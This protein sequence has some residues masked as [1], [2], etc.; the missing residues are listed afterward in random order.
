[1]DPNVPAVFPR[2]NAPAD[3]PNRNTA[4]RP[5]PQAGN[6]QPYPSELLRMDP[7]VPVIIPRNDRPATRP[8]RGNDG[9][10][11][12]GEAG[13]VAA[14][15]PA[16][17]PSEQVLTDALGMLSG[18]G[19]PDLS[20][21]TG[22]NTVAVV[23][24]VHNIGMLPTSQLH[25]SVLRAVR[26]AHDNPEQLVRNLL[27]LVTANPPVMPNRPGST[28]QP[29][30]RP[31]QAGATA[32]ARPRMPS[33]DTL[34]DA[35]GML[36][37]THDA[38]LTAVTGRNT[39]NVINH[40][41]D[42]ATRPTSELASSVRRAARSA[43]DNPQQLVH[44]LLA[45]ATANPPVLSSRPGS[46]V[47]TA[48]ADARRPMPSQETL[49]DAVGM[50]TGT[51]DADL[52]EVTGRNTLN[53]I[54][55]LH[56]IGTRSARSPL[57]PRVREAAQQAGNDPAQL[58][59]N[60]L[61]LATAN[62][63]VLSS[64]PGSSVQTAEADAS[65]RFP[66]LEMLEAL[67]DAVGMLTGT[68]DADLTEL[69]ALNTQNVIDHLQDIVAPTREYPLRPIVREAAQQAGNNPEQLVR[70]LL[71][72]VTADPPVRSNRPSSSLQPRLPS[73]EAL[74]DA[75]GMLTGARGADLTEVTGRNTLDVINHLHDI[76]ARS[77]TARL[78][79]IVR[80]AAQQADNNPEQLVRNLLA[81][82]TANPPVL[83]DRP[84]SSVQPANAPV[85]AVRPG[86]PVRADRPGP[87]VR[88]DRPNNAGAGAM[89][90]A[91]SRIP[92]GSVLTEAAQIV[93][94]MHGQLANTPG[95]TDRHLSDAAALMRDIMSL[96]PSA[97]PPDVRRAAQRGHNDPAGL[98]QNLLGLVTTNRPG[99]APQQSDRPHETGMTRHPSRMPSTAV[100]TT[101]V[102]MLNTMQRAGISGLT[103]HNLTGV[104]D[105]VRDILRSPSELQ[106]SV[107][108]AARQGRDDPAQLV[109][110]LLALVTANPPVLSEQGSSSQPR[111]R[112]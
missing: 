31:N 1:M 71:A 25:P 30:N 56:D 8:N 48:A 111:N 38:D 53:V 13:N 62:P 40:L 59:R 73:P 46:S 68:H 44:N 99:A 98:L 2:N 61:A 79:P 63:P 58:V 9:P 110:N 35:V 77:Q 86:S 37:G 85:V 57:D 49:T 52:T 27:A 19:R 109:R 105:H 103:R 39:L 29:A 88:A 26:Q 18:R 74:T 69:T 65:P 47:Q 104:L 50:L 6:V 106:P 36:T 42:I 112:P 32:N 14:A 17:M 87:S 11:R 3:R 96:P 101:A 92:S 7:N 10:R 45:L 84:G 28:A 95:L 51:H 78:D 108:R 43:Q 107:R 41:Q 22:S 5:T 66:S 89:A 67:T 80:E 24:H 93:G 91:R 83:S 102:N 15:N 81:L 54:N 60:L 75:I 33:Q 70:N 12:H 72:L 64:R 100:M 55:H 82:V 90:D 16:R 23:N 21:V 76:E 97:L 4:A 94:A 20:A 34:T